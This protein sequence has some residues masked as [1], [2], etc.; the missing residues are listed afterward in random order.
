MQNGHNWWCS[1]FPA[2]CFTDISNGKID[3]NSE[4]TLKENLND[5]EM[6]ILLEKTPKI[7][8]KFKIIE[9]FTK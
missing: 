5:E 4:K 9:F 2:L 1:L 7:Q 6:N 3:K 8:F